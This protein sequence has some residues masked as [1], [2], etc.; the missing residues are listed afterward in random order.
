MP[1]SRCSDTFKARKNVISTSEATD[2]F[3]STFESKFSHIFPPRRF[4]FI[5]PKMLKIR[6]SCR[7]R[8]NADLQILENSLHIIGK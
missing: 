2:P 3:F 6:L 1:T 7:A 5:L 8:T 4:V